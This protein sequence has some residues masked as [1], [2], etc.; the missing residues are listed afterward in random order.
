MTA[1]RD[2]EQPQHLTALRI[3]NHVR[4][5]NCT[6]KAEIAAMDRDTAIRRVIHLIDNPDG[7]HGG[8]QLG[9]LILAIPGFGEYKAARVLTLAGVLSTPVSSTRKVRALTVRQ[10]VSIAIELW[11]LK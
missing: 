9:Q 3:A 2:P 10:R 4:T 11:E 6:L 8:M 1:I 7:S 5:A